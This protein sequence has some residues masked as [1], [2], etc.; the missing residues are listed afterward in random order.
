[1]KKQVYDLNDDGTIREIYVAEINEAGDIETVENAPD[2]LNNDALVTTDLPDGLG[3]A[4]W[5]GNEWISIG[6]IQP[7]LIE[8]EE[9]YQSQLNSTDYKIIKAMEYQM[10]GL[11]V[12]YN[13]TELYEQRQQLRDAINMIRNK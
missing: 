13:L 7:I 4:K 3:I 9:F 2:N 11:N 5:D 10:L 1:M 12:G 6:E 8:D